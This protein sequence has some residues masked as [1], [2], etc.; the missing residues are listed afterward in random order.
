MLQLQGSEGECQPERPQVKPRV[1]VCGARRPAPLPAPGTRCEVNTRLG[2]SATAAR[3]PPL[4]HKYC[5]AQTL[6][7]VYEISHTGMKFRGCVAVRSGECGGGGD[8]PGAESSCYLQTNISGTR[9]KT[10]KNSCYQ[11]WSEIR[12]LCEPSLFLESPQES[13]RRERKKKMRWHRCREGGDASQRCEAHGRGQ[14]GGAG[15]GA[16]GVR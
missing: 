16:G 7:Q 13:W 15:G 9:R 11:S 10:S 1:Q 2:Y 3:L 6:L 12:H 5:R 14:G 8:G 4:I